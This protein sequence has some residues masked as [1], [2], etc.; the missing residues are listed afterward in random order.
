MEISNSTSYRRQSSYIKNIVDGINKTPSK[1]ESLWLLL[2]GCCYRLLIVQA[3]LFFSSKRTR[4]SSPFKYWLH[5]AAQ[6]YEWTVLGPFHPLG[7]KRSA[8]SMYFWSSGLWT[9]FS[10]LYFCSFFGVQRSYLVFEQAYTCWSFI[11]YFI[12]LCCV[13]AGKGT[14]HHFDKTPG[15]MLFQIH[16]TPLVG[17]PY[18]VIIQ[19]ISSARTE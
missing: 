7:L 1:I 4:K 16:H 2:I 14:Q 10:I 15:F 19:S 12:F 8:I 17:M 5:M 6:M 18:S 11:H 13:Q 9:P 3:P